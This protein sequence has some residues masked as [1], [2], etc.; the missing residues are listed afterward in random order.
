MELLYFI[1]FIIGVAICGGIAASGRK[2][3]GSN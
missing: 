2:P 1:L 3:K